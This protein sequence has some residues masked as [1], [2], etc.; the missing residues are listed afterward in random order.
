MRVLLVDDHTLVRSGVA[1]LIRACVPDSE[2]VEAGSADE[3]VSLLQ[4]EK[5]D[6]ALVDI[7]LPGRD[8][9]QLLEEVR[10][11]WPDVP[12]IMLTN[13]DNPEYVKTA[14]ASGAS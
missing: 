7:R 4:N 9:L 2:V 13:Y 11:S 6:V 1:H 3:A 8:G 14:M 10:R 12:V 5:L